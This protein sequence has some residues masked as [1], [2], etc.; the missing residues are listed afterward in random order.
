[1]KRIV[2]GEESNCPKCKGMLIINMDV[3]DGYLHDLCGGVDGC[4][5]KRKKKI[6][7]QEVEVAK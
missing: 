5:F 6:D 7:G 2:H 3:G 4:G 1:M